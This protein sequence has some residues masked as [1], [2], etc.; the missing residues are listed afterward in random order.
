MKPRKPSIGKAATIGGGLAGLASALPY[1]DCACCAIV[2]CGGFLAAYIYSRDCAAARVEFRPGDGALVG[3]AAG[4]IYA[5]VGVL[6]GTAVQFLLGATP[7]RVF[8]LLQQSQSIPQEQI[9]QW[10]RVYEGIGIGV[11]MVILL[12]LSLVI[13]A[14]FSTIGGLIGGAVFQRR[15]PTGEA[16][17]PPPQP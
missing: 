6:A 7:E 17:E 16:G 13:G 11:L 15:N 4:P 5:V 10:R 9:E 1:L 14:I 2:V 8:Q 12:V 3:L